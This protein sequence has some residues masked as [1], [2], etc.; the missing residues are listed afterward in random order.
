MGILK[1]ALPLPE[2]ARSSEQVISVSLY[3]CVSRASASQIGELRSDPR[4]RYWEPCGAALIIRGISVRCHKLSRVRAPKATHFTVGWCGHC[5]VFSLLL[6]GSIDE[7]IIPQNL[8]LHSDCAKE[9]LNT[10][11]TC[12]NHNANSVALF[13][14]QNRCVIALTLSGLHTVTA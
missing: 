4:K 2:P 13:S 14:M 6:Q 1:D 11:S 12:N 7:Y 8:F 3:L 9:L 5:D 10:L